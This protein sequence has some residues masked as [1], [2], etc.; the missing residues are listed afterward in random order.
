MKKLKKKLNNTIKLFLAFGLLFNNL[1][2]LS[3]VFAD[4]LE[5][6]EENKIVD[7]GE[8]T[9]LNNDESDKEENPALDTNTGDE[10]GTLVGEEVNTSGEETTEPTTGDTPTEEPTEPSTGENSTE[11]PA[12]EVTLLYEAYVDDAKFEDDYGS[13]E[14]GKDVKKLDIK[15]KLSGV[16]ATENYSFAFEDKTYTTEELLNG[17][18]IKSLTFEGHLFGGFN[19]EIDGT[20]T[21]PDGTDTPYYM[22]YVVEFGTFEDNDQVLSAINSDYVFADG[23][24][25]STNYDEETILA[26]AREAFP[27]A[28]AKIEDDGLLL[29][30]DHDVTVWYG[31][32]TKGDVNGDGKINQEDLELLIDQIL[33]LEEPNENSDINGDGEVNDSDAVCLKLMLQIGITEDVTEED[34]TIRAKF[35]EFSNPVKVGDEFTLEYLV[36]LSE[37]SINGISGLVK[38]DKNLLEL[39]SAEAKLFDLG[40]MNED[41]VLYLGEYLDLDVEVEYDEEGNLVLD[42]DG[43][44]IINFNDTDYVLITLTFKAKAVGSASVSMDDVKYYADTYYY[45]AEGDTSIDVTI[46]GEEEENPFTSITVAGYNVDLNT[47]ELTVP[48]DVT[49]VNLEYLLASENYKVTSTLYPEELVEGENTITIVVAD[50]F[51]N[52]KEYTIKVT[53]EAKPE[54]KVAVAEPMSYQEEVSSGDN[55]PIVTT[56]TKTDDVKT[57]GEKVKEEKEVDVSRIIIIILILLVIAGLI[58][59]IFKDDDDEET[60]RANKEVDKLR[61]ED[62]AVNKINKNNNHKNGNH[63]NNKNNKKGR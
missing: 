55:E 56:T 36:T 9:N 40:G 63:N 1:M 11:E 58:Y 13:V 49:A 2:P 22:N 17:V 24:V 43:N 45:T 37:Y 57:D 3:V 60:K 10:K 44:P 42:E 25:T 39:L 35:G 51:G 21:D 6:N 7:V 46:E 48:N 8:G 50:E 20:L 28:T 47:F 41:K 19:L 53:R 12:S 29:S 52:E 16:E 32:V 18:V 62:S 31:I 27:N 61:K 33:G 23:V 59:L 38:Y 14:L 34:A 30:D 15:A 26:I 5:N 4:E 54:E